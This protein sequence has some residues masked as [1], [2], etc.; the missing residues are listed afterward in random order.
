[1]KT[2]SEV[3]IVQKHSTLL[4]REDNSAARDGARPEQSEELGLRPEIIYEDATPSD[5]RIL[6]T[7]TA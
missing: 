7:L 5:I 6:A 4:L 2:F 1:M 3:S